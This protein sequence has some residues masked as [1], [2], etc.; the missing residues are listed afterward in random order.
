MDLPRL[1]PH[2]EVIRSIKTFSY[3]LEDTGVFLIVL[4]SEHA[5]IFCDEVLRDEKCSPS[6]SAGKRVRFHD[7]LQQY[8][9]LPIDI[10]LILS[11]SLNGSIELSPTENF[12]LICFLHFHP[13]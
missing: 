13:R 3:A 1:K 6:V 5:A 10:L 4:D 11:T 8:S 12:R 2:Y 9:S 7:T